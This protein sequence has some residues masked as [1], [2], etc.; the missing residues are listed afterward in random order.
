[1]SNRILTVGILLL[2]ILINLILTIPYYSTIT[3]WYPPSSGF[4][5][6]VADINITLSEKYSYSYIIIEITNK[7]E[8][9]LTR[10]EV[11]FFYEKDL[12][13]KDKNLAQV[14]CKYF[15]S[16]NKNKADTDNFDNNTTIKQQ[17][18]FFIRSISYLETE[19][20]FNPTVEVNENVE[21]LQ[22]IGSTNLAEMID[23]C[24]EHIYLYT[25]NV[26][27][28]AQNET[29]VNLS[30]VG[31]VYG[32]SLNSIYFNYHRDP[33]MWINSTTESTFKYKYPK[34]YKVGD[35]NKNENYSFL[36]EG[37][38]QIATINVTKDIKTVQ[39]RIHH[40]ETEP[41]E[42]NDYSIPI[43][44]IAA[45][46]LIVISIIIFIGYQIKKTSQKKDQ[47]K[48]IK[49]PDKKPPPKKNQGY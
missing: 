7:T 23:D 10:E 2:F 1:M 25:T 28:R 26:T 20:L 22:F 11:N 12:I 21:E 45:I 13:F 38:Y 33:L 46:G 14:N 36:S 37:D 35:E 49:I 8:I 6:L 27:I 32:P 9:N 40:F 48:Q 24:Y 47:E 31:F 30:Y 17:I 15:F 18:Y 42:K 44:A 39:F 5:P 34:Y 16:F 43:P 3:P 41:E 29:C 19:G 4:S